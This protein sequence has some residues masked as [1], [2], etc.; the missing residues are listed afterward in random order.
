MS[1]RANFVFRAEEWASRHSREESLL[2][3]RFPKDMKL[4]HELLRA[5]HCLVG[6]Y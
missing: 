2:E 6:R 5:V 3:R 1:T 4:F